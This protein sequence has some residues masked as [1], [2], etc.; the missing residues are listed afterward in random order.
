MLSS[1]PLED[2]IKV[3]NQIVSALH[4]TVKVTARDNTEVML[5]PPSNTVVLEV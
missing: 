5:H 4:V 2:I 1:L 3:S